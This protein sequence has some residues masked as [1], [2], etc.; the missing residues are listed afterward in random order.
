MNLTITLT[1]EDLRVAHAVGKR[2]R[3]EDL[4]A[5]HKEGGK[6]I[7]FDDKLLQEIIGVSGEIAFAKFRGIPYVPPPMK[8]VDV[9]GYQVRTGSKPNY[10]LPIRDWDSDRDKFALVV[11]HDERTYRVIGWRVG[12]EARA[13]GIRKN[14]EVGRSA[15]PCNFCPQKD[16]IPFGNGTTQ[17]PKAMPKK[18]GWTKEQQGLVDWFLSQR[19]LPK[20]PYP[21]RSGCT[22]MNHELFYER[23]RDEIAGGAGS[24]R[25]ITGALFDDLRCLKEIADSF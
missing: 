20:G 10:N 14:P 24:P 23:L 21:L 2:R 3:E 1:D 17:E 22:V 7:G 19:D 11:R 25:S 8:G 12:K 18:T 13:L 16:M 15:G 4:A 5:G 6:F 9:D